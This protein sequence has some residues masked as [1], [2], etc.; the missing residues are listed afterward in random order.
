[1]YPDVLNIELC[2]VPYSVIRSLGGSQDSYRQICNMGNCV[3][4]D[5]GLK[6]EQPFLIRL[7]VDKGGR[8]Q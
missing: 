4:S 1:M 5:C 8:G 6:Q 7:M 3:S 2:D